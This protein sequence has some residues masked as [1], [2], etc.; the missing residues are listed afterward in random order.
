MWVDCGQ[1]DQYVTPSGHPQAQLDTSVEVVFDRLDDLGDAVPAGTPYE[2]L[3][4]YEV[5]DPEFGCD[6]GAGQEAWT[7]LPALSTM[8]FPESGAAPPLSY[9]FA[10]EC[11]L[12]LKWSVALANDACVLD[13]STGLALEPLPVAWMIPRTD[14]TGTCNNHGTTYGGPGANDDASYRGD[15]W[16]HYGSGTY[17]PPGPPTGPGSGA[18]LSDDDEGDDGGAPTSAPAPSGHDAGGQQD[19]AKASLSPWM[20]NVIGYF[21]AAIMFLCCTVCTLLVALV[22][23]R[24]K[25]QDSAQAAARKGMQAM[26]DWDGVGDA[27]GARQHRLDMEM[28]AQHARKLEGLPA[29]PP[30]REHS[31]VGDESDR[32]G[33][34]RSAA[35]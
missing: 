10:T 16:D 18:P 31:P 11:G 21:L 34:L 32:L 25:R 30:G 27:Y 33:L 4:K 2:L 19:G 12:W 26:D 7:S 1:P 8:V 15:G 22:F 3:L 6:G 28:V 14:H 29:S 17:M 9:S 13:G 24:S 23:Y 20:L 35:V 5:C